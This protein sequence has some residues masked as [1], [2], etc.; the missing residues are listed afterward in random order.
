MIKMVD[1]ISDVK[2]KFQETGTKLE[3]K[4]KFNW[5][6]LA[7]WAGLIIFAIYWINSLDSINSFGKWIVFL[8]VAVAADFIAVYAGTI[9]IAGDL[10]GGIVAA[11]VVFLALSWISFPAAVLLALV[12]FIA[13]FFIIGPVPITTISFLILKFLALMI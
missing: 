2:E 11:I 3:Q 6:K 1:V 10:V 5:W 7:L 12:A 8:I 9:P 4:E 13:G